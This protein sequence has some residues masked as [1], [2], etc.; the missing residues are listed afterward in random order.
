MQPLTHTDKLGT[1]FIAVYT[2]FTINWSLQLFKSLLLNWY[3][4][5]PVFISLE[6][7]SSNWI[8]L[9]VTDLQKVN[10]RCH[11]SA[12]PPMLSRISSGGGP[13]SSISAQS[14]S[15]FVGE[16]GVCV[17]P[18][19]WNLPCFIAQ[20]L[21]WNKHSQHATRRLC[22]CV[23]VCLCVIS[24]K[25]KTYYLFKVSRCS[26]ATQQAC[27]C[28]HFCLYNLAFLAYLQYLTFFCVLC[29]ITLNCGCFS[30]QMYR[31]YNVSSSKKFFQ[32]CFSD[33]SISI[34]MVLITVEDLMA[35]WSKWVLWV[36]FHLINYVCSAWMSYFWS[37][38]ANSWSKS[39][40]TVRGNVQS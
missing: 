31:K 30:F 6:H 4:T 24:Q 20:C 16:T 19:R 25:R 9:T 21:G 7:G 32:S 27:C 8:I 40:F 29:V 23:C 14:A 34:L 38:D 36:L 28:F 39:K 33:W 5:I 1:H 10:I 35:F 13:R 3:G 26:Q 15:V 12:P 17:W 11:T 2:V 37:S 22:M 18:G